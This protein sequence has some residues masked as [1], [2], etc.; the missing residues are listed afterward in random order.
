M[1]VGSFTSAAYGEPRLTNDIDIVVDLELN[2]VDELCDAFPSADFYVSREAARAALAC[3]GQFNVIDPSSGNKVDF[4]ISRKDA[5]GIEQLAR[6]QKIPL[7]PNLDVFAAR[8]EDIILSKLLYYQEGGSEKHLRDIA[9][10]LNTTREAVDRNY[11]K[12]R[13]EQFGLTDIWTAVQARAA[14][15]DT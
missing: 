12:A 9:G 15:L 4:M 10:I 11:I 2:Q 7:L 3:R 14:Q 8:P 1:V 5:W 6:R 13:V